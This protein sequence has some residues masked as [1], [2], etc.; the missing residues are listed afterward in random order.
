MSTTTHTTESVHGVEADAHAAQRDYTSRGFA[1][2]LVAGCE[3]QGQWVYAF[4]V[5]VE[6]D[7]ADA[8]DDTECEGHESTDGP[9]G[10]V[11]FCDGTCRGA[12]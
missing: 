7:D 12:L 11:V 10:N 1:T 9:I 4:D 2:S 8:E 6:I 5:Y 3:R